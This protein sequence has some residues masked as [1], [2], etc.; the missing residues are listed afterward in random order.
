M[1]YCGF[2]YLVDLPEQALARGG[3]EPIGARPRVEAGLKEDLV[4]IDVTDPRHHLMIHQNGFRVALSARERL[5]KCRKIKARIESVRAEPFGGNKLSGIP[6]Q[7]DA[8]YQSRIDISE[9]VSIG[10]IETQ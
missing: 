6:C 8:P 1:R 2:Q 10:E 7:P 3:V 4:G 9:V 5:L